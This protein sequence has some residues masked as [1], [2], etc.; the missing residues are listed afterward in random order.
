MHFRHMAE[1]ATPY[2]SA[3]H[4]QPEIRPRAITGF[5]QTATDTFWGIERAVNDYNA[6]CLDL[7]KAKKDQQPLS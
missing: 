7:M 5:L 2:P 1:Q 4:T 6:L 3:R